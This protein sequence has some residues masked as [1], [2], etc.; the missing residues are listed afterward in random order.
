[1]ASIEKRLF[2]CVPKWIWATCG[3]L[4]V[5][6]LALTEIGINPT[7]V[8]S[9]LMAKQFHGSVENDNGDCDGE[10]GSSFDSLLD[11]VC[12]LWSKY[13]SSDVASG[14]AE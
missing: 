1:M 4:I 5:L 3:G 8:L 6:N 9:G 7:E 2:A 11:E 10:Q 13:Q 14:K 12:C